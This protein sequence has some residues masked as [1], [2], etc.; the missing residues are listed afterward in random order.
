MASTIKSRHS[1]LLQNWA[2]GARRTPL[3]HVHFPI[4]AERMWA[5][6]APPPL[7][8]LVVGPPHN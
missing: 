1:L 4:K 5:Q 3:P 2:F 6:Q 8:P 7:P